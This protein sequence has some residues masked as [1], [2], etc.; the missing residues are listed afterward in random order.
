MLDASNQEREE[1][2]A[3]LA[4]E[5]PARADAVGALLRALDA[6]SEALVPGVLAS[7]TL[8]RALAA[9][10]ETDTGS[11]TGLRL[12][13]YRVGS[14]L[15]RG[16]MAEVYVAERE[17]G[18]FAQRVAIK[19]LAQRVSDS[20]SVRLFEQERQ[21]LADL[22]HPNIARLL[23]G[24][25]DEDGR[26]YLVMELVDGLT[27]DQFADQARLDVDARLGAFLRVGQCSS[28]TADWWCTAISSPPTCS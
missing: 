26:P 7:A 23:D 10:A 22:A 2:L 8:W 5:H 11:A 4:R 14:A 13:P 20:A 9:S 17:D 21:I 25:S 6:P 27:I 15:G 3:A 1:Q 24:G 12:G 28:P 18:V 19:R 16:G